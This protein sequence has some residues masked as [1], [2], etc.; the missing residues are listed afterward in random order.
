MKIPNIIAAAAL[1]ACVAFASLPAAADTSIAGGL[2]TTDASGGAIFSLSGPTF[3]PL[4]TQASLALPF[5]SDGRYSLTAE[6]LPPGPIHLGFGGGFGQLQKNGKTGILLDALVTQGIAPH[7]SFVVRYYQGV[8][9]KIG[10][11]AF[12]GLQFSL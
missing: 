9:D 3:A 7:T 12:L 4:A 11:T 5:A 8:A 2:F 6:I 1:A 10:S